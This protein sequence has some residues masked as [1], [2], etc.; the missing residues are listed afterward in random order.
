MIPYNIIAH[1]LNT[2][3]DI[4]KL[5]NF[6]TPDALNKSNLTIKEKRALIY[7]GEA[8]STPYRVFLQ[9]AASDDA[10]TEQNCQFRV[11]VD[12]IYPVD[13]IKS[14]VTV[15]FEVLCHT[16]INSLNNYSTRLLWITQNILQTFNGCN[17][18]NGIGDL[19]FNAKASNR[20]NYSKQNIYNGK[21]YFGMTTCMSTWIANVIQ[22][23][24]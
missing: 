5:L 12:S 19:F 9:P 21:N 17:S 13:Q 14:I 6:N 18:I 10:F 3:E 20:S 11:Y 4:W 23:R 16:K 2:N 24:V 15:S 1:M 22:D 7:K 8:D